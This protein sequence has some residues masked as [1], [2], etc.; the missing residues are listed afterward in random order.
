VITGF[1]FAIATYLVAV[2]QIVD[3]A[4]NA[5]AEYV[6]SVIASAPALTRLMPSLHEEGNAS[7]ALVA[8]S[9][10]AGDLVLA[11]PTIIGDLSDTF[12]GVNLWCGGNVQEDR[13]KNSRGQA[14]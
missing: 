9:L 8:G 3:H 2:W 11:G 13:G 14:E 4:W 10:P 12:A 7:P 1:S 6:V 5:Y